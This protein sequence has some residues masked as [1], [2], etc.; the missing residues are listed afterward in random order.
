MAEIAG[1]LDCELVAIP[2]TENREG[3]A[4]WLRSGMQAMARQTPEVPRPQTK[5]PLELYDLV[6]LGTPVWA[7]RC[8]APMR[9][10]LVRY[11]EELRRVAYVITRASDTRY[12][13]VF[14]QM[15]MYV[16]TPRVKAVSIRPNTVGS[17]FWRDEFL[18][19]LRPDGKE[20]QDA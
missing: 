1:E 6:I 14:D 5:L 17:T 16:K 3:L 11:G 2:D 8:S 12:E 15:D 9:G 13:E 4:G 7:G 19:T 10:F 18:A 20:G